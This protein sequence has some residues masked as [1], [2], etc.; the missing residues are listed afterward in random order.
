M[1]AVILSTSCNHQSDKQVIGK[2]N[3]QIENGILSPETLWAF[4]RVGGFSLSPDN[5]KI[6]YTVSYYSIA[7]NKGNTDIFTMGADGSNQCQL[8]QTTAHEGS[9]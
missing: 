1:S 9:V 3:P 2:Q 8:T 7:E 5:D 4:G 6:A